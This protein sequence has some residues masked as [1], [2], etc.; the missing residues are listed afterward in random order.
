M[1]YRREKKPLRFKLLGKRK[2]QQ[3]IQFI[4]IHNKQKT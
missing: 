1:R 2:I 3:I 4:I